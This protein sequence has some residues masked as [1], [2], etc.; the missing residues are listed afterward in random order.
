MTLVEV[1][2]VVVLLGL[3]AAVV[4]PSLLRARTGTA[5]PDLAR[6]LDEAR[7]AAMGR[8]L[9]VDLVTQ[10]LTWPRTPTAMA[11]GRLPEAS[12]SWQDARGQPID[13]LAIDAHGRHQDLRLT[14][15]TAAGVSAWQI[16][17][18]AG[19]WVAE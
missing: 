15:T 4:A 12:C 14:L 7:L 8:G 17:G 13:R 19:T 16:Q 2:A 5:A 9:T 11:D 6:C 18:I 3:V 10:G 1:L